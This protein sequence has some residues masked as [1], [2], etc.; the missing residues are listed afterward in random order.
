MTADGV[1]PGKQPVPLA[2][3]VARVHRRSQR[4]ESSY[5]ASHRPSGTR[6]TGDVHSNHPAG[7]RSGSQRLGSS[8]L[9]SRR[10]PGSWPFGIDFPAGLGVAASGLQ[11]SKG[12]LVTVSLS[13]GDGGRRS[14]GEAARPVRDRSGARTPAVTASSARSTVPARGQT[15]GSNLEV[16]SVNAAV[17]VARARHRGVFRAD[18][19]TAQ[20]TGK[21]FYFS[22]L[23]LRDS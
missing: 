13:R 9:F 11:L 1:P 6:S 21:C 8:Y 3:E 20:R 14:P 15:S 12:R 18:R 2:T 17:P 16:Y 19:R 10:L 7:A 5:L 23:S 22:R 4:S